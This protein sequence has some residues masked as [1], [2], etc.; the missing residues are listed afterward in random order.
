L[1]EEEF[2]VEAVKR[3]RFLSKIRSEEKNYRS[4]RKEKLIQ[5]KNYRVHIDEAAGNSHKS[6]FLVDI[7]LLSGLSGLTVPI[8]DAGEIG[9]RSL[10]LVDGKSGTYWMTL[11]CTISLRK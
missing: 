8:T 9:T 5:S 2:K 1:D 4:G 6:I 10:S 3:R 11:K 7:V